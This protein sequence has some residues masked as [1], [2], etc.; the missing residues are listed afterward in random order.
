MM[1]KRKICAL[2]KTNLFSIQIECRDNIQTLRFNILT[3]KVDSA[4]LELWSTT[5]LCLS[6]TET[7]LCRL[8]FLEMTLSLELVSI[9]NPICLMKKSKLIF[10]SKNKR[11][12]WKL[13]RKKHLFKK[14][15]QIQKSVAS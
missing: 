7:S 9:R 13:K 15:L 5:Y 1:I 11:D 14:L 3:T 12:K 4:I 10:Q 6:K 8:Y 2:F